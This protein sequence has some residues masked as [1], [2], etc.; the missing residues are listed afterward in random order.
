MSL[1]CLIFMGLVSYR[2][3]R[4]IVGFKLLIDVKDTILIMS[5]L[6]SPTR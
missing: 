3:S 5:S 2:I 4:F 1:L 6:T